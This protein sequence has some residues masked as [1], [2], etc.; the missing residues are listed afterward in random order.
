MAGLWYE[1]LR[2]GMVFE[3]ELSRT[4]TEADNM[5]FC[6]ATLNP[7]PLHID[8][9]HA[10][11]TEFG[12]PLVN[13]LFTLGLVIGMTVT[14]T[15]LGTTVANLGMTNTTFPAPVFFG[16][17]V[18]TRT[19]VVSK[20]DSSSRPGQGIVNFKH[21]GLNQDGVVVCIC[22]RAAL[23]HCKPKGGEA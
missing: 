2:E 19:T 3:H 20:R 16:D 14:D 7:Q 12:K 15:T 13:S 23:M 5:W 11:Q 8:Y 22:E 4:V 17:T 18:R 21:E 9:H 10:A 6:N 1:E